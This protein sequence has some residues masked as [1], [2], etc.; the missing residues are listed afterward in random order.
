LGLPALRLGLKSGKP[1]GCDYALA[2]KFAGMLLLLA[3][4]AIV[5]FAIV[6]FPRSGLRGMFVLSGCGVELLGLALAFRSD[7]RSEAQ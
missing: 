4:W 2:M 3:G 1:P 7:L 5:V 6:L